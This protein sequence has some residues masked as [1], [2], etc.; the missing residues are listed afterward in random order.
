MCEKWRA[1]WEQA[2]I[3]GAWL[4]HVPRRNA[5]ASVSVYGTGRVSVTLVMGRHGPTL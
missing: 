2:Q 4:P 1:T 5:T 3:M